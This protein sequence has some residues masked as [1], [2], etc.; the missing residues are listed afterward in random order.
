M[1]QQIAGEALRLSIFGTKVD[2]AAATLP[3]TTQAP[4]FSITGGR[5]ALTGLV[6]VVVVATSATTNV[7]K[8]TAN[9][10]VGSDVDLTSTTSIASREVGGMVGLAATLGGALA[11]NN[12]GASLL[13]LGSAYILNTGTLDLVTTGTS[14]GTLSWTMTYIPLD[15]GASVT[16][17]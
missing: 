8:V 2:R 12:A 13:P 11:V 16:A 10:A 9:P 15:D 5:V 17:A 1:S 7:L 14:T 6:G 4:I 3:A